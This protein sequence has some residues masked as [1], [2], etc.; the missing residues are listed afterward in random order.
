MEV[1]VKKISHIC[2]GIA[3]VSFVLLIGTRY[4]LGGW[5]NFAA[6]GFRIDT[7]GTFYTR[8]FSVYT[9]RTNQW[10]HEASKPTIDPLLYEV[11]VFNVDLTGIGQAIWNP[12][13]GDE[14]WHQLTFDN[15]NWVTI[16]GAQFDGLKTGVVT[17]QYEL[18]EIAD[19]AN[20]VGS[21]FSLTVSY[22]G[23]N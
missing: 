5:Q 22:E 16:S 18:R 8:R 17:G 14:L 21:T 10:I 11:R 4:I 19:V 13:W 12:Y 7:D 20:V 6:L 3:F 9:P 15:N 2:L 1:G 23:Q